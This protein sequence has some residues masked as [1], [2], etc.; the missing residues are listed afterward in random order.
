MSRC[1]ILVPLKAGDWRVRQDSGKGGW[2][3][4]ALEIPGARF[5]GLQLED[6]A[7]NPGYYEIHGNFIIWKGGSSPSR[8]MTA[9]F[10]L[11]RG[12]MTRMMG[13]AL[14][15]LG[16]SGGW[17]LAGAPNL[18]D[19]QFAA[20]GLAQNTQIMLASIGSP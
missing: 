16:L 2:L 11:R 9:S 7:V 15:L 18:V 10:Q 3:C 4:G 6:E 5:L 14:L 1:E 12:L 8:Q 13:V 19:V 17:C 20:S